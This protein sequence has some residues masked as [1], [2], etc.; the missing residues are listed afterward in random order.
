MQGLSDA[1]KIDEHMLLA[2][3]LRF[4]IGPCATYH[5]L[6]LCGL[7]NYEYANLML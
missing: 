4:L 1:A 5:N 7:L 3:E 6:G 2:A